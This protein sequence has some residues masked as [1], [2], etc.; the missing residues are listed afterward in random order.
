M[1]ALP[2]EVRE[3]FEGANF[4]HL[5]TLM[6]DGAP[7]SVAVWAGLEGDDVVFFTQEGSLKARNLARDPRVAI[8]ITDHD[9]PYQSAQLRGEVVEVRGAEEANALAGRLALRYTGEPF[10][11]QPPTSRLFVVEVHKV[12]STQLGFEHR[13][14]AA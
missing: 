7:H 5:A 1:A 3:L 12:R 10:P 9:D 13:P 11:F 6:P 4:A 2:P 14:S 8:S